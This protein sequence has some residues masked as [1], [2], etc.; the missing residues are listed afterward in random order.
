ML[1]L[2][3]V[4]Q[5]DTLDPFHVED[6]GQ[7]RA[8]VLM[9]SLKGSLLKFRLSVKSIVIVTPLQNWKNSEFLLHIHGDPFK[10]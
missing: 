10:K 6:S 3:C 2:Y 8:T 7:K 5:A 4:L 1:M 9:C